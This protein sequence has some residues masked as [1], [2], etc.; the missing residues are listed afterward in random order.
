MNGNMN[1]SINWSFDKD[2]FYYRK[3]SDIVRPSPSRA[4]VFLD[5]R[6]Q[7]IDDG[8]FLVFLSAKFGNKPDQWGNL[9]ATYHNNAGGLSFADGHSEIKRWL[10]DRTM[11]RLIPDGFVNDQLGS[12]YN[13]DVI[14]L[15]ER[16]TRRKE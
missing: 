12:P 9:P 1:G 10:D 6:E 7:S 16:A 11:P 14:W 4:W 8:F 13:K 2:Y 3:S 5:E 15:Q